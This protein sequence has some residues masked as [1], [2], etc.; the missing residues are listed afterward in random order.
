[1]V[2]F[3][4]RDL[5]GL[6]LVLAGIVLA[7][8]GCFARRGAPSPS[9][10]SVCS[11]GFALAGL[12]NHAWA[13]T[14]WPPLVVTA[15]AVTVMIVT[16]RRNGLWR[17]AAVVAVGSGLA[18]LITAV[19][20]GPGDV[21]V[22]DIVQRGTERFLH[23]ANP[24]TLVLASTGYTFSY[25]PAV[26]LLSAPARLLGD[27]RIMS[28]VAL[29]L[30]A[31]A[32]MRLARRSAWASD[33]RLRLLVVCAALP[34]SAGIVHDSFVDVYLVASV[35]LWLLIRRAHPGWGAVCLGVALA[36][37][38][39]V[40]IALVPA[41][42]WLPAAR[43]EAAWAMAVALALILPFAVWTGPEALYHAVIGVE[44]NNPP[45]TDTMSLDAI[46]SS[47]GRPF[48][49]WWIW[50]AVTSAVGLPLLARR[51]HDWADLIGVAAVLSA[52]GLFFAKWAPFNYWFLPV[53]LLVLALPLQGSLLEPRVEVATGHRTARVSAA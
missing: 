7:V 2:H 5:V 23:G 41:V 31:T 22:Y 20:I 42:L 35:T 49:P 45:R 4:E 16:R 8:V 17:T 40:A 14:F 11:L 12:Y 25:G 1:M 6:V 30:T 26:L 10:W 13:I 53:V 36:A 32:A 33:D 21:D 51:P 24:Y 43:R 46:L 47:I 39:T 19:M 3:G 52:V 29:L 28:I 27:V 38:P 15:I 50:P 34:L 44:V 48:A 9:A 37:K 18:T